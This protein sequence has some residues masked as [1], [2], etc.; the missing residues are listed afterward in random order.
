V[1]IQA[2][3]FLVFTAVQLIAADS[4]A[5][6]TPPMPPSPVDEFRKWLKMAPQQRTMALAR[7]PEKSRKIIEA[8]LDEYSALSQAE[9]D[10]RLEVLELR[11]YL[12]PLMQ[13]PPAARGKALD[14][15]PIPL[16]PIVD[17]RLQQWDRM[18]DDVKKEA[19]DHEAAVEYFS[20]PPQLQ[21]ATMRSL[22]ASEGNNLARNVARLKRMSPSDRARLDE[23]VGQFFN[24]PQYQQDQSLN[25]FSDNER[26][27]MA[28]TLQAFRQ[29]S[30]EQRSTCI[31]AFE[32]FASMTHDEQLAFLKNAE[33]WQAMS[34]K[35]REM[36]REIVKVV[37]PMP[38]LG[39]DIPPN[40]AV[41]R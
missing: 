24:L 22:P 33:R 32:K 18:S 12:R 3:I 30:A 31:Q 26:Q 27:E 29:L 9:R 4:P 25:N 36:W 14:Q 34:Q 28:K 39:L 23:R 8:K 19:L 20:S 16:R 5:D 10:R 40:P 41:P 11:W 38:D 13:L 35:D 17:V 37:P 21:N 6:I 15:V 7:R 2:V 1:R